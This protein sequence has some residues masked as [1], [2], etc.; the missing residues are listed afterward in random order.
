M[1]ISKAVIPCVC[2][3]LFIK[4]FPSRCSGDCNPSTQKAKAGGAC[5]A[6]PVCLVS[7]RSAGTTQEDTIRPLPS[8]PT[9][10]FPRHMFSHLMTVPTRTEGTLGKNLRCVVEDCQRQQC[11]G[12][13]VMCRFWAPPRFI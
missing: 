7:S 6:S 1:N 10:G 5:E 12:T 9:P 2:L 11:L 8:V 13:N 3:F 4:G